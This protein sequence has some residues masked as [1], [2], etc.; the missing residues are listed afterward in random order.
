MSTDA[1]AIKKISGYDFFL[2]GR[3]KAVLIPTLTNFIL[4]DH[5]LKFIFILHFTRLPIAYLYYVTRH[6]Y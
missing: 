2:T 4:M 5:L 1:K 3:E 6:L